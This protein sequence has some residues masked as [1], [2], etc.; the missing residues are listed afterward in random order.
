MNRKLYAS[1][2]WTGISKNRQLYYPYLVA[3]ITM[4][5]VFYILSFLATSDVVYDLPG[6]EIVTLLFSYGSWAV[7]VFSIPFLFYTNSSLI[8]KRKKELGLYNILGMNKRN[9]F[10]ILCWEAL[11]TYGIAVIGGIVA[12]VVISKIAELGIVNIMKK[13]INYRIYVE[14]SSL[15]TAIIVFAIIFLLILFNMLR[16]IRN[17]N[18]IELLHSESEGERPPKSHSFLA[19]VSL[20]LL[21]IAYYWSASMYSALQAFQYCFPI[22]AIITVGTYLL[23]LCVSI[24]LCRLLQKNKRYYYKTSHFV[25]ISSM[26]YRM[27]RNGASLASICVL[28]T[29]ILVSFTFSVA[30]FTGAQ[31]TIENHYPYDLGISVEI[32]IEKM[33][34]EMLTGAYANGY[35]SELNRIVLENDIQ[36]EEKMEAHSAYS[37][38]MLGLIT[39]GQLDLSKDIRDTWF[40]PG[41]Y[42]GWERGNEKIVLVRILSLDDY[43]R[44]CKVSME[45]YDN[46]V[47]IAS[48]SINYQ[49][50]TVVLY[51]GTEAKVKEA[52]KEVPQM[53]AV[54]MMTSVLEQGDFLDTKG[55]EEMYL[56]VP[57]MYSF[58][59]NKDGL[60]F[61]TKANYL[62]YWWEYGINMHKSDKLHEIYRAIEEW[63]THLSNTE[64]IQEY[65][66]YLKSEKGERFYGLAG[67]L[68]FLMIIINIVFVFVTALIMYYKQISEGYED[69]KRYSIMRKIG[70]TSKEIKKSIYSQMLTVFWLPLFVAGIHLL[71]TSQIVYL[72]L[73]YAVL[74]NKPLVIKV[75]VISY[76]LFAIVY[77]LVYIVTSKTYF[78]IV[79]RSANE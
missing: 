43:N 5:T 71:F 78:N 45:I 10:F 68:L 25:T 30:F 53:T 65:I 70:M 49:A 16:Q 33:A 32:P 66:C 54:L 47:F 2:A 61:Y 74:D 50:N 29:L 59:G 67:G 14:W 51:D 46:E 42:D 52:V 36:P 24:V 11:I 79:S 60:S 28:V 21:I 44:L 62:A 7:G 17:S 19:I 12:G 4:V 41:G 26:T 39:D 48:E 77:S 55:I 8:K 72:L 1:L 58:M 13:D 18:P 69:Q 20:L 75:M 76:C 38:N 27:K 35:L 15:F 3:A 34:D 73:R 40:E 37:A 56:V 6:G 57:D 23:F 22:A 9:I 31:N 63:S 64:E